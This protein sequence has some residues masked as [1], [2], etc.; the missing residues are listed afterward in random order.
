M[1]VLGKY[2]KCWLGRRVNLLL[3]HIKKLQKFPR[4]KFD[5]I[6]GVSG[7]K[8]S[9]RQALWVRDKLKLRPLLVS[10]A[11]PPE[12]ITERGAD[13][14]SNLIELGFDVHF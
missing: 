9:T 12:Q 14:I 5:C 8:D 13:N 3:D 6:I 1:W 4:R 10:I 2:K 11:Y 7:G